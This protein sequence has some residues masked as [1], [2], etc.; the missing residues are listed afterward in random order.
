MIQKIIP[1]PEEI[2]TAVNENNLAVFIGAGVSRIVGC[3]GWDELAKRLIDLCFKL[4]KEDGSTCINYKEKDRLLNERDHKK[5]IT[6]CYNILKSNGHEETFYAKL[7]EA[8]EPNADLLAESP[9]YREIIGLHG[10]FITTNADQVFDSF[11]REDRII[12]R[13]PDINP[14]NID[15]NKLYH[16]HG[17]ILDRNTLV[18]TVRQ[19]IIR[20]NK[21]DFKKFLEQVFDQYT[22]LFLGY[23]MAEFELL[24]FLITKY[25]SNE[26]RELKHFII[27]PYYSGEENILEFDQGYYNEMCIKVLGYEF[28]EKG[29]GQLYDIL[30]D[31]NKEINQVSTYLYKTFDRIDKAVQDFNEK[32]ASEILQIIKNDKP[33]EDHLFEKLSKSENGVLWLE[34]LYKNNYFNPANNP[35]PSRVPD[36]QGF[37]TIEKWN[38]LDYLLSVAKL[39]EKKP[40][41]NITKL[42]EA[43]VNNIIDYRTDSGER[44]DNTTTDR[45]IL[46]IIFSLPNESITE[47]HIEWV[48]EAL[49]TKWRASNLHVHIG[50][51]ALP[52]LIKG[53]A[54]EKVL[55]LIDTILHYKKGEKSGSDK[56]EPVLDKY[57]LQ[58]ALKR[59]KESIAK[60]CGIDA[61]K[62][63]IDKMKA[64]IAKNDHAFHYMWIPTIE[65]HPQTRF[66]DKYECQLVHLVRDILTFLKPNAIK[67][68]V[69]GF[70]KEEHPIFRRI[71]FHLINVHYTELKDIFWE[72]DNPLNDSEA[73]HEIYELMK[74]NC[75][76][77]DEIQIKTIIQWVNKIHYPVFGE[78][79][80]NDERYKKAVA[81]QK[82]EWLNSVLSLNNPEVTLAYEQYDAISPGE[83]EHPGH[84][85]WSG[86]IVGSVSPI[87]PEE[88]TNMTNTEIAA[89]LNDFVSDGVWGSPSEEGL[90]VAF[91]SCIK[92]DPEKFAN[93]LKPF[94]NISLNY[95]YDLISGF[96]QAWRLEK[97]FSWRN[98]LS[99]IENLINP[100]DF[101]TS[102]DKDRKNNYRDWIISQILELIQEGT[103]RDSN[104]F[105]PQYLELAEKILFT[106]S[107]KVELDFYDIK[108]LYKAMLLYSL[109]YARLFRKDETERWP[110]TMKDY[111]NKNVGKKIKTSKD[112]YKVLGQYLINLLYLDKEWVLG[113]IS[114]IFP[115]DDIEN[116][117][118]A[119]CGYVKYTN[120]V[121]QELYFLLKDNGIWGKAIEQKFEDETIIENVVQ[122]ICVSYMEG[123]EGLDDKYSLM[124]VLIKRQNNYEFAEI[125][126]FL[127]SFEDNLTNDKRI[128]IKVLWGAIYNIVKENES[129][130]AIII[131]NLSRWISLINEIDDDVFQWLTLSARYVE[132]N[133]NSSFFIEH[134]ERLVK[135]NPKE[136][137]A[138]YII[139]LNENVCPTFEEKNITDIVTALY[140]EGQKKDADRICTIYMARGHDFLKPVYEKYQK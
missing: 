73:E 62:I 56:F 59:H 79:K 29:Y 108:N 106:I 28:D 4:K 115:N 120:K 113:N 31:W 103:R 118:T 19:Y 89:Y 74:N 90:S 126:R 49:R 69:E 91:K 133:Y 45:F 128:R 37:Y 64:V 92:N 86:T 47:K 121:Y 12:F 67:S 41:E 123:W 109:R 18:F 17:S 124:S 105:D 129:E 72:L 24:D 110:S 38:I 132:V 95:K 43:I 54:K 68:I 125:V 135:I 138:L 134:F 22:V 1:V 137:G 65:D 11:F 111:F 99:F 33:Q 27:K 2:V 51:T 93:D 87:E 84:K 104:A 32:D 40:D 36:K 81:F 20:Y 55:L 83:I 63:A 52:K 75:S 7:E 70:L 26:N 14:E 50:T 39:K 100:D 102:E 107:E 58:K 97:G 61:V 114:D 9:I 53:N 76:N 139:M 119:F 23:G 116:W 88:L 98:V 25:D 46:Q 82:K 71:A 127:V 6:I 13:E 122:H 101:W 10:L 34:L 131:S 117:K 42:L 78:N 94:K 85:A 96:S 57:W 112:F 30:K 44:V 15:R 140:D 77:F 136:V 8:L 5:T 21:P 3:M 16:I 80:E 66:T 130:F 60:L 35:P 48:S